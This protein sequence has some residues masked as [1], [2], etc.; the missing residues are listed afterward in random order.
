MI[1]DRHG[2]PR[3]VRT[4]DAMKA[5]VYRRFGPPDVLREEPLLARARVT[6]THRGRHKRVVPLGQITVSR[7]D[8]GG[9]RTVRPRS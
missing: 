3:A 7:E 8:A 4:E 5:I 1:V 2:T 6:L 9:R